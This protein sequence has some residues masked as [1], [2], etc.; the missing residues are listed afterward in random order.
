VKPLQGDPWSARRSR[1]ASKRRR[2]KVAQAQRAV[3][4]LRKQYDGHAA[5]RAEREAAEERRRA[6]REGWERAR[7]DL[8]K[9]DELRRRATALLTEEPQKRCYELEKLLCDRFDLFDLDPK[10]SFKIVGED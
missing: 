4:K 8:V 7:A 5:I 9:L 3:A 10:A 6:T 1:C 2:D